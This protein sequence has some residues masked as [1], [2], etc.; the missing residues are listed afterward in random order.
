VDAF[1]TLL[2]AYWLR[3]ETALW[4]ACDIRAMSTF[5]M[6]SPSLDLGCGDGVFSFVRAGGAFTDDFDVFQAVDNVERFFENVDVYDAFDPRFRAGIE[7]KPKY[8]IDLGLDHKANLLNKARALELYGELKVADAN[9]RL[10]LPDESFRSV[11]SNIVYW[12]DDP[13]HALSEIRR[14]LRTD[15]TACVLL[16]NETLREFSFFWTHHKKTGNP[17]FEFLSLLDR[18]RLAD[19]VRQVRST[20]EWLEVIRGAG[21]QVREHRQYL[22]RPIVQIWDVGLRP[23]FPA[24][25]KMAEAV[26]A[27]RMPQIKRTWLDSLDPLLRPFVQMDPGIDASSEPAFHCFVLCK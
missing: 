26:P 16:P 12:L 6:E 18:G 14:V 7:R 19:N 13:V 4:R 3:P 25:V 2:S 5:R 23:L 24:L 1:R 20:A 11:F 22:A 8:R 9:A 27:E 17:D 10:P 15:G 21:L